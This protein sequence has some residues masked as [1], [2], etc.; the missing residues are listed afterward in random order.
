[1]EALLVLNQPHVW[2]CAK[3][4]HS[5][6]LEGDTILSYYIITIL[7]HINTQDVGGNNTYGITWNPFCNGW[8]ERGCGKSGI[9]R[10]TQGCYPSSG[11]R[12]RVIPYSCWFKFIWCSWT[13]YKACR[14]QKN[15]NPL[16]VSHGSPFIVEGAATVA[17]R[18][19]K[20]IQWSS[21]SPSTAGQTHLMRCRHVVLALSGMA[22]KLILAVAA[23][24]GFDARPNWRGV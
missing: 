2:T 24:P 18:R 12:W 20:A 9:E 14:V 5:N 11:R 15:L 13:S 6:Y 3:S 7:M 16:S 17:Y 1:M 8:R 19:W 10:S 21:V 22:R 23:S 4:S